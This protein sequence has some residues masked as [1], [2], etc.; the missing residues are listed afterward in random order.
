MN[1]EEILDA[2][3]DMLEE[4]WSIPLSGNKC[5]I[6]A[7]K[8]KQYL[9]DIRLNMPTEIKQAKL[10]VNDRSD[11]ISQAEKQA[12]A[13]VRKAEERAKALVAQEEVVR[14]AQEKA[15]EIITQAQNVA[16]ELRKAA[17][18]FSD[19][20]LK[21]SEEALSIALKNV[22]ETRQ[23]LNAAMKK[24]TFVEQPANDVVNQ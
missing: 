13:T 3:E 6:D 7:E 12:E 4:A 23:E 9:E 1:I 24:G 16:K 20:A 22:H 18:E 10:I 17:N 2:L 15:K 5:V 21:Q 19:N 8:V 14:Q 11:I